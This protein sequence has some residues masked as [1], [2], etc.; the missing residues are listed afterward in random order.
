MNLIDIELKNKINY[1]NNC[2]SNYYN[3]KRIFI[4]QITNIF[5]FLNK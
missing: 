2:G 4:N 5:L 1:L 3:K